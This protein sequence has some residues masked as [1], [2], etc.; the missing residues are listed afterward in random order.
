MKIPVELKRRYLERRL[1]DIRILKQTV[2][3]G[4][5]SQ[6]LR[7]GHQVKGNAVTFEVPQIAIIGN[8]METAARRRDVDRLQILIKKMEVAILGV[9]VEHR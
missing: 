8:E 5:F 7:V 1:D 6:A 3:K 2:N 9:E 4:D